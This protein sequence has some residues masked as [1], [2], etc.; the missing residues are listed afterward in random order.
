MSRDHVGTWN[1]THVASPLRWRREPC[2]RRAW[3]VDPA[4]ATS[5]RGREGTEPMRRGPISCAAI[6][7]RLPVRAIGRTFRFPQG[8]F[9]R[10]RGR[11]MQPAGASARNVLADRELRSKRGGRAKGQTSCFPERR[12]RRAVSFGTTAQTGWE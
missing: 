9:G 1:V 11:R 5:S 6:R 4:Y 3:P 7:R 2:H 8:R 10:G 12:C